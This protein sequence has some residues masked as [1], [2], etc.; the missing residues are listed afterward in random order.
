M[1]GGDHREE[2]GREVKG[3][4]FLIEGLKVIIVWGVDWCEM[5][6]GGCGVI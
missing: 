2:A 4:F 6:T 5:G 3:F 1:A